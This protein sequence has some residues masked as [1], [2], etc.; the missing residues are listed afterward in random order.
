M[1]EELKPCPICGG[2]T[3]EI[4]PAGMIWKGAGNYSAPQYWR[5]LH[6]GQLDTDNGD[7]FPTCKVEM[8][9]R[10]EAQLI[11]AWNTRTPPRS[12]LLGGIR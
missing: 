5:L 11:A 9:H 4:E 1:I 6:W 2:S 3:V 10:T 12:R 8:R 7:D